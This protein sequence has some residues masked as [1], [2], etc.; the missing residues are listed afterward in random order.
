MLARSFYATLA[1]VPQ[2]VNSWYDNPWIIGLATGLASGIILA[3]VTPIILRR[4]RA[5]EI[6]IRQ[7]RAAE[8][9]LSAL[10]PSVATGN[11]PSSSIVESVWRASAYNRGLDVKLAVPATVLLDVLATEVMA[12][13][14]V[15]S[16]SRI[17]TVEQLLT[18]RSAL[19]QGQEI[20]AT[21]AERTT[22]E[23]ELVSRGNVL[24][25]AVL[26]ACIFGAAGAIS[27]VLKNPLVILL[28]IIVAIPVLGLLSVGGQATDFH[29]RFGSIRFDVRNKSSSDSDRDSGRDV[30]IL[31]GFSRVSQ[32]LYP[33]DSWIRQWFTP[34]A[35][36]CHLL[37]S[38][39][40]RVLA[41]T[42]VGQPVRQVAQRHGQ[43]GAERVRAGRGQLPADGDG[44]LDRGQR[45]LPPPQLAQP[46]R[47]GVAALH[48]YLAFIPTRF[49]P[50]GCKRLQ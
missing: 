47:Q 6:A 23:S 12:S 22:A 35:S 46:D 4:R 15:N 27:V 37:A 39:G 31:Q 19:E 34:G 9:F 11:F 18:L 45:L 32:W 3:L 41:P 29:F 40:Q 38:D 49:P 50:T 16:D 26:G 28:A 48:N 20:P 21:T 17:A 8:D 43:A 5:R 14:F 13:P 1:P 33:I 25:L 2:P 36:E 7:E 30:L 44:L 24:A 10:R 42:Q